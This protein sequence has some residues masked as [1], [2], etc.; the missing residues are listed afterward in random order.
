ML[1]DLQVLQMVVSFVGALH[2]LGRFTRIDSLQNAEPS[3]VLQGKLQAPDGLAAGDIL[4][5]GAFLTSF[6]FFY[7]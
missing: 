5:N 3:E 4:G 1:E 7:H 2:L 6:K